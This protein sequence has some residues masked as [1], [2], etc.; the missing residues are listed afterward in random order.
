MG[1]PIDD[2]EEHKRLV[3]KDISEMEGTPDFAQSIKGRLRAAVDAYGELIASMKVRRE[4]TSALH[5]AQ[6]IIK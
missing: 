5:P 3:E 6:P 4:A 2:L 1:R